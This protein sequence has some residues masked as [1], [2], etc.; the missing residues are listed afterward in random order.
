MNLTQKLVKLKKILLQTMII[1]FI[2]L[3]K[4]LISYYQK[5]LLKD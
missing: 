3:L 4:N 1:V 5:R 2:L